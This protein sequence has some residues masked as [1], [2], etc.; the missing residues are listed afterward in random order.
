LKLLLKKFSAL[1][2]AAILK[3]D[4]NYSKEN[5]PKVR[6]EQERPQTEYKHSHYCTG[7]KYKTDFK[8]L[9]LER[10]TLFPALC[11]IYEFEVFMT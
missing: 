1:K 10:N 8:Y 4:W 9:K 5:Q 7:Q 2:Y 11:H 3:C 6:Q